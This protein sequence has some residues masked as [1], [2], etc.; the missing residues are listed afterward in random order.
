MKTSL[1]IINKLSDKEAVKLDS[2]L[3]ELN[4]IE[5]LYK[6]I[7][8]TLF[9][10]IEKYENSINEIVK[11]KNNLK[12]VFDKKVYAEYDVKARELG[13]ALND[14]PNFKKMYDSLLFA[15]DKYY[16]VIEKSI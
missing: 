7:T 16:K 10:N 2:Q 9:T 14:I 12:K 6:S 11:E 13:L 5:D 8:T 3:V 4:K 1:E 15:E